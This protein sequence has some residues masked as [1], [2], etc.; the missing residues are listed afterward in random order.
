MV[1]DTIGEGVPLGQKRGQELEA[2]R[3]LE[4]QWSEFQSKMN[5]PPF[6][7]SVLVKQNKLINTDSKKGGPFILL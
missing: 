1:S 4:Q 2:S 7:L 5:G 6:V 3:S